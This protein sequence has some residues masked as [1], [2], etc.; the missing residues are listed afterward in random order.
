MKETTAIAP[1]V[2]FFI[3]LWGVLFVYW[4]AL[5]AARWCLFQKAGKPG[6]AAIVPVYNLIVLLEIAGKPVWWVVLFFVP[7]VNLVFLVFTLLAL[8]R[9]FGKEDWFIILFFLGGIGYFILGFGD[10]AYKGPPPNDIMV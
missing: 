7:L 10:A 2:L 9:A 5:V 4:V 8:S 3:V 6:W 1:L